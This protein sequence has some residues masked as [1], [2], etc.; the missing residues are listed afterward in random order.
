[1]SRILFDT[2][3][4]ARWH[5][6]SPKFRLP[7]E[8]LFRELAKHGAMITRLVSVVTVQELT[9]WATTQG[10][11]GAFDSWLVAHFSPP[12]ILN[13]Q[14]AVSAAQ[15]QKEIGR[16][17]K[18][19]PKSADRA[20]VDS[21]F[22]D[23]AIV[24]TAIHHR[25]D[26]IVTLD[27]PLRHKFKPHFPGTIHLV[28]ERKLVSVPRAIKASSEVFFRQRAWLWF[29]ARR[30]PSTEALPKQSNMDFSR[31]DEMGIPQGIRR[32]TPSHPAPPLAD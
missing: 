14:I 26:A 17:E 23:A 5:Q 21:W 19:L 27:S 15:L 3:A 10:D 25:A 1:M 9:F 24:A 30:P 6:D 2:N 13:K 16:P 29:E 12:L 31:A 11:L 18:Q 28:E 7:M 20:S 8:A 32:S 4:I 22:R